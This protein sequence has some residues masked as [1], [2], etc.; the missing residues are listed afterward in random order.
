MKPQHFIAEQKILNTEGLL[1]KVP[2]E[3]LS[4]KEKYENA[5]RKVVIYLKVMK[6]L[7]DPNLSDSENLRYHC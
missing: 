1:D 2:E 5:I 7:E 6:E 3:Y 4:H